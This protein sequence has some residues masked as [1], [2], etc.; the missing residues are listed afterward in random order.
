MSPEAA[1]PRCYVPRAEAN[2]RTRKRGAGFPLFAS[3]Q[4]GGVRARRFTTLVSFARFAW[5][6]LSFKPLLVRA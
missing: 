6:Y 5:K 3:W 2:W 4:D 1:K